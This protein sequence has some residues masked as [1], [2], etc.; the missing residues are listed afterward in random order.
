[1]YENIS[2]ESFQ[3][4]TAFSIISSDSELSS[5]PVYYTRNGFAYYIFITAFYVGTYSKTYFSA[6]DKIIS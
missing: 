1:M 4:Q 2:K 3:E 6:S 5:Q